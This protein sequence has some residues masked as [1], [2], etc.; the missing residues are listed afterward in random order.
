MGIRR[1]LVSSFSADWRSVVK[2]GYDAY[3]SA[4]LAKLVRVEMK[5]AAVTAM[6]IGLIGSGAGFE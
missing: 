4:S 5:A 2:A 3:E 1:F 6:A